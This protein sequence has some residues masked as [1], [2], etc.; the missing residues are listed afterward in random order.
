MQ[1]TL[2]DVNMTEDASPI[3]IAQFAA[4]KAAAQLVGA[5]MRVGLGTSPVTEW[6]ARCLAE[7]VE[8]EGLAC[9]VIASC[10]EQSSLLSALGLTVATFDEAKWL[11][12][13]FAGAGEFDAD[14]NFLL[15]SSAALVR[16][17]LVLT[18][19]ERMVLVSDMSREVLKIGTLPVSLEVTPEGAGAT[20]LLIEEAL[21]DLHVLGRTTRLRQGQ[22]GPVMS[23]QGNYILDLFPHQITNPRRMALILAQIPGVIETGLCV[24]LCDKAV[25]GQGDGTVEMRDLSQG[26]Q[27][28]HLQE[29]DEAGNIFADLSQ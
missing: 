6:I 8:Q 25:L 19:T 20:Q 11:D 22:G 13:S 5:G 1:S 21:L 4:A 7:R 15:P 9:T 12:I 26:T 3:E 28:R 2:R 16:E 10:N 14:L 18:A 24:D 17:K 27:R 29:E 23:E